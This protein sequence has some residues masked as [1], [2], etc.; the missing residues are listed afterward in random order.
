MRVNGNG[1]ELAEVLETGPVRYVRQG[2][3]YTGRIVA[4]YAE[5]VVCEKCGQ[6]FWR[7][8]DTFIPWCAKCYFAVGI[9][10]R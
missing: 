1:A 9:R 6:P 2:G 10:P 5:R 3:K 4:I 7:W 8:P